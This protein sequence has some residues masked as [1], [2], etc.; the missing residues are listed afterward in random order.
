MKRFTKFIIF[1]LIFACA[2]ALVGCDDTPQGVNN[3]DVYT[4]GDPV[5]DRGEQVL[6]IVAV[7]NVDNPTKFKS[8]ITI[9]DVK[10]SKYL[11]GKEV[12]GL[13]YVDDTT[14]TVTLAGYGKVFSGIT[15]T[16]VLSISANACT[17]GE[18]AYANVIVY[19]KDLYAEMNLQADDELVV[20]DRGTQTLTIVASQ[21]AVNPTKFKSNITKSDIVLGEYLSTKTIDKV[22]YVND[23]TIKVTLTGTVAEF[24]D[25]WD[26]GVLTVKA[27]A[28]TLERD[29]Y[30]YVKVYNTYM[31]VK[32][33]DS[34][35]GE[36][37]NAYS[38]YYTIFTLNNGVYSTDFNPKEDITLVPY[39]NFDAPSPSVNG[40]IV[41]VMKDGNRLIIRINFV[42][43]DIS[44][45]PKVR[46]GAGLVEGSEAFE[47]EIGRSS[48]EPIILQ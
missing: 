26:V 28:C 14:L 25:I 41:S 35:A 27:R 34:E 9:E 47:I 32:V 18:N 1:V 10:L 2:L 15:Q 38:E 48:Y 23:T 43:T 46:I 29:C 33:G 11:E 30:T 37:G 42:D 6:T 4:D 8:T 20:F 3:L 22:E 7:Q 44:R 31:S 40:K 13:T 39:A 17:N 12:V 36:E 5:F 45:Y 16:G 24:D 19:N 21:E